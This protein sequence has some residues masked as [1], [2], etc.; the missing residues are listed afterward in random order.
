[1]ELSGIE[2]KTLAEGLLLKLYRFLCMC[3]RTKW[4]EIQI[5]ALFFDNK[6]YKVC[7]MGNCNELLMLMVQILAWI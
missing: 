5:N 4:K 7:L 1:M 6:Q 2:S 3:S